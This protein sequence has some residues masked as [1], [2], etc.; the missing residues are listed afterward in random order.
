M[1][2]NRA[3]L[4]GIDKYETFHDLTGC[5]NDVAGLAPLFERHAD[6]SRNFDVRTL[7]SASARAPLTTSV[8]F[9]Q[10]KELLA[11]G[12]DVAL[13]YFAGH[14]A[15]VN[16]E[17]YLVAADGTVE[18]PGL[19]VAK[20]LELVFESKIPEIVLVLDCCFSGQ[21]GQ[22]TGRY[23]EGALLRNGFSLLASS[24]AD[25]PSAENDGRGFFSVLLGEALSGAARDPESGW[26]T[27]AAAHEYVSRRCG[28]WDQ[29]PVLKV[30]VVAPC[31]L[32]RS[33][34]VAPAATRVAAP[35]KERHTPLSRRTKWAMSAALIVVLAALALAAGWPEPIRTA[36]VLIACTQPEC[37]QEAVTECPKNARPLN[38]CDLSV[39]RGSCE[40][41]RPESKGRLTRVHVA[42]R[43]G[44]RCTVSCWC[45][46]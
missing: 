25:Q 39:G 30:N 43:R 3:L 14:A 19:S 37:S 23:R 6:G 11:P 28:A 17:L 38:R 22:L 20:I 36:P 45:Q 44:A 31:A 4:V 29:Q 34:P 32:R 12:A 33:A 15:N 41:E 9:D 18:Q 7:S 16:E 10:V 46:D 8:L 40:L 1:R 5:S 2:L 35:E 21:A 42:A 13:F 24:R 26:V 27:L